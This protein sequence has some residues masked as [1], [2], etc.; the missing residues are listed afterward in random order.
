MT[1]SFK[2]WHGFSR[3][4]LIAES[5]FKVVDTF[6]RYT[7]D[8]CGLWALSLNIVHWCTPNVAPLKLP[9]CNRFTPSVAPSS[10]SSSLF[11]QLAQLHINWTQANVVSLYSVWLK[12]WVQPTLCL[13][14]TPSEFDP[15]FDLVCINCNKYK[16]ARSL[17]INGSFSPF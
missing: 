17:A 8:L 9:N 15:K 4:A 14:R 6:P 16:V 7:I 5:I 1:F 11:S 10:R 3:H 13:W 2:N 12:R